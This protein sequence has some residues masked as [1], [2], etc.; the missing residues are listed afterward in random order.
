[1]NRPYSHTKAQRESKSLDKNKCFICGQDKNPHSHHLIPYALGGYGADHNM[2]TLC[3][4]CHN[5][6]HSGK[7]LIDI[8]RF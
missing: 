8:D 4:T 5:D 2:I 1:M 7:L 3:K 6:Y